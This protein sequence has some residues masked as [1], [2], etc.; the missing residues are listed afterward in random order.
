MVE[1]LPVEIVTV[2][3]THA[4]VFMGCGGPQGSEKQRTRRVLW[5]QHGSNHG[6]AAAGRF[7]VA[8]MAGAGRVWGPA[9]V[10]PSVAVRDMRCAVFAVGPGPQGEKAGPS[11][12]RDAGLRAHSR[13]P[14]GT[15]PLPGQ[16]GGLSRTLCHFHR[17]LF[18]HIHLVGNPAVWVRIRYMVARCPSSRIHTNTHMV[19]QACLLCWGQGCLSPP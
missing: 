15:L 11:R 4:E 7:W 17:V 6:E 3:V 1:T 9:R 13:P 10:G 8:T 18:G 2:L 5:E 19:E 14:P 12:R 16:V